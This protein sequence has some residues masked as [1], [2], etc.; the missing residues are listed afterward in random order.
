MTKPYKSADGSQFVCAVST[1]VW[2]VEGRPRIPTQVRTAPKLCRLGT[3]LVSRLHFVL[4]LAVAFSCSG[5][6]VS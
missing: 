6:A 5:G 4:R 3:C 1:V 2:V